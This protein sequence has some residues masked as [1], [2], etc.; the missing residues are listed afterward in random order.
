MNIKICFRLVKNH[1]FTSWFWNSSRKK[2]FGVIFSLW[3]VCGNKQIHFNFDAAVKEIKKLDT[4]GLA[5]YYWWSSLLELPHWCTLC[6]IIFR[7]LFSKETQMNLIVDWNDYFLLNLM[8]AKE[9]VIWSVSSGFAVNCN[10]HNGQSL[11]LQNSCREASKNLEIMTV[12][13]LCNWSDPVALEMDYW[14]IRKSK[15][16]L[17]TSW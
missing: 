14:G 5:I 8:F 13:Y 10:T 1:C 4:K 9:I 2:W 12:V 3:S 16:P 11:N 6:Q 7:K 15:T 17:E